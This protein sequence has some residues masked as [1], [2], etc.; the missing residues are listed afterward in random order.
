[1]KTETERVQAQRMACKR[2]YEKTKKE[3]RVIALRFHREDDADVLA[4]F[5]SVPNKTE[6]VREL[7]RG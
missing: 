4:K 2:Y 7:V 6:F 3:Y 5:D 1:M